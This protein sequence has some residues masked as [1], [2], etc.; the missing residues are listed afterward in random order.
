MNIENYKINKLD[1][2][3]F[4]MTKTVPKGQ[5][6]K[7]EAKQGTTDK[8]IGYYPTLGSALKKLVN[9]ELLENELSTAQEVLVAISTLETKID[10]AYNLKPKDM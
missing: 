9:N 1:S 8:F 7:E 6:G 3:Q 4:V 5:F 2:Y 10:E